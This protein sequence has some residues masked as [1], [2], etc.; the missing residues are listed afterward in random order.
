MH[1][2]IS[3]RQKNIFNSL[4]NTCL[5]VIVYT[6]SCCLLSVFVR[7]VAA[8]NLPLRNCVVGQVGLRSKQSALVSILGYVIPSH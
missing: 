6:I 4:D 1:P 8:S 3:V 5:A 7:N 2:Y